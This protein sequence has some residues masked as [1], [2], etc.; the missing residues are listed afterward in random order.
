MKRSI[1]ASM[2]IGMLAAFITSFFT[3]CNDL[4]CIDGNNEMVKQSRPIASDFE[5]V[6]LCSD[7]TVF[8]THNS[9]DSISVEAESNLMPNI[10][11]EVKDHQLELKTT[12]NTCLNPRKPVIIRIYCHD[13]THLDIAGSGSVQADSLLS[14]HL[15]ISVSGSGSIKAPLKVN[16]LKAAIA[17]SGNI[18]IWGK[19]IHSRLDVSGSGNL[20]SYGLDQDSCVS[21][22]S[23]SGNIF[24]YVR[25]MLDASISGSG[26]VYYK[27]NP[28]LDCHVSGTG[29][30]LNQQN[31][32]GRAY[33]SMGNFNLMSAHS[34]YMI[35]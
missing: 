29:K 25:K 20:E 4:N 33:S 30:V 10:L 24:I 22:I 3:S 26:S 28:E 9:K 2:V 16:I 19:A 18:E 31:S 1:Y 11:T 8:I 21:S 35:Y 23:G 17:G 15:D 34:M 13:L 7:Y 6:S 12:E 32:T 5:G 27:G 14:E